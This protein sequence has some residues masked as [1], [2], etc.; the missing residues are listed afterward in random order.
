MNGAPPVEKASTMKTSGGGGAAGNAQAGAT[1]FSANCAGCHGAAGA[2][3]A[4]VFPPLANNAYVTG[5]A[6]AVIHTLNYGLNGPIKV[7]DVNYN[8]Q[9]PAWKGNLTDQQ[10][11]DVITYIRASWGNKAAAVSAADVTA[12]AK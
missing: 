2:G 4:G 12:V 10:I 1:V 6:K 3:Q 7:G 8:G 9:M 11:A 5:D